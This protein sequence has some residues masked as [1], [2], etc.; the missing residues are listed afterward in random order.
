MKKGQITGKEGE[1]LGEKGWGAKGRRAELKAI[2][3]GVKREGGAEGEREGK[4]R[5]R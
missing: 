3:V 2:E 4:G 1:R 5:R